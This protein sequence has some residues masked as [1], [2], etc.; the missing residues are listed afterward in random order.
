MS[1][2]LVTPHGGRLVDLLATPERAAELKVE[3]REMPSWA[4]GP[5]QLAD[6]ELLLNGTFSPLDR[7]LGR[8]DYERVL[9]E[10]RLADGTLWPV[11]VTLDVGADLA[12]TLEP[13]GALALRDV[14]GTLL[15]VLRIEEVWT[16]DREAEARTVCGTA[17]TRH[18]GARRLLRETGPVYVGGRLEGVEAPH[19]YDFVE[20]RATPAD[21]R[22]RFSRWGWRRIAAFHT[23]GVMHRAEQETTFSAG[24]ELEASLLVQLGVARTDYYDVS[25]YSR[26]RCVE[27][28]MKTYPQ[29]TAHLNLL[30]LA[31][32]EAG[33]RDVLLNALV[34]QNFGCSHSLVRGAAAGAGDDLLSRSRDRLEIELVH[35]PERVYLPDRGGFVAEGEAPRGATA[36]GLAAAE[37][38]ERLAFGREIPDW[39]SFPEVV[40]ELRRSSPPRSR[41]GFTVFFTGLP[42]SGKSTLANVLLVK[43]LELG[44]RPVTLLDGDI[45][46]KN[47]SSELGF[48]REHRNL[49]IARI[50]FVASEITKNGGIAIC[51]P[52]AP[53]DAVRKEVRAT[54]E[55]GGGFLLV[56]VATP[57]EVCE[58]RDRKGLY[59]KARAGVVKEFT[60]ISDPYEEPEDAGLV[61]DTTERS[62]E[63]CVQ[64]ILLHLE[65]EGYIGRPI[66]ENGP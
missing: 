27:A 1:S 40:R 51:A 18:P 3:A 62:P 5:R 2:T 54:I 46:R 59:A 6:L 63:E 60:G 55:P 14:E 8:E 34:A 20:R 31:T 30:P 24:R 11:P 23:G 47:L 17:D 41:Q 37:L 50:G 32:R 26:V 65:K 16:P 38:Q 48:S 7:F 10:L 12:A 33:A 4:L 19:H 64:S 43:L 42:S 15:A 58:Q 28:V 45:V 61:L 53:Y 52:I 44:G 39:F 36:K 29:G 21:L 22:E 56:H 13:G 57:L 49:N 25:H 9:R 66:R 35:V